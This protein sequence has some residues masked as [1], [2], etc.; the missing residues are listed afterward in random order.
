MSVSLSPELFVCL[1]P[2]GTQKLVSQQRLALLWCVEFTKTLGF[3][4][5]IPGLLFPVLFLTVTKDWGREV[6]HLWYILWYILS[7]QYSVNSESGCKGAMCSNVTGNKSYVHVQLHTSHF[8]YAQSGFMKTPTLFL[9]SLTQWNF[10]LVASQ[11]M[12]AQESLG[13]SLLL[14]ITL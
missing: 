1:H 4:S 11:V 9:A 8:M 12:F 10:V 5:L 13:T 6:Y 2:W 14:S 3:S 7:S